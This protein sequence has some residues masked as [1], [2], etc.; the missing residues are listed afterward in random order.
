MQYLFARDEDSDE[1]REEDWRSQVG[2]IGRAEVSA[3]PDT[4]SEM[5]QDVGHDEH[6]A[7]FRV[8]HIQK[9]PF[10]SSILLFFFGGERHD[11]RRC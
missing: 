4:G 7:N 2:E 5:K 10:F 3:K 9:R 8:L 11:A 6:G 1:R